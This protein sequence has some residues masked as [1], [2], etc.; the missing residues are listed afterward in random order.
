M[1]PD[2]IWP[3]FAMLLIVE[4]IGPLLF[5]NRWQAYLRKLATEPAQNLRQLGL[6]LVLAGSCWLWWLT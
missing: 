6:V 3:A 1:M 5:P 2:W 4:G